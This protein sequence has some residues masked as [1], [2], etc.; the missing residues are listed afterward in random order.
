[1]TKSFLNAFNE[2]EFNAYEINR[3]IVSYYLLVNKI[4][5]EKNSLIKNLLIKPSDKQQFKKLEDLYLKFKESEDLKF[6]F[7]D[8]IELFELVISPKE[9]IVTGAVYTPI[10][11]REF[12]VSQ[13]I[14][15]NPTIK[16]ADIACGCGGFLLT[17][18]QKIKQFSTRS[19]YDIIS[20]NLW[21]ID[22]ADYSVERTKI[23][24][25]LLALQNGEDVDLKF[26]LV[27]G[28]SLKF[29]WREKDEVVKIN[30][31]FDLIVGNP[32]YV[33]SRNIDKENKEY[34]DKWSV[35]KSGHPDLYIPFFQIAIENLN[36]NGVLGYITVNTFFKS[37]NGRLLREYFSM[38]SFSFKIIDFKDE[39]VFKK[40]N[41]YTCICFI[42]KKHSLFIDYCISPSDIITKIKAED[43]IKNQYSSLDNFS[44]WNLAAQNSFKAVIS[45]IE[46]LNNKLFSD[47]SFSTGIA[48]LKNSVFIFNHSRHDETFFY[49][50]KDDQEFAIEKAICREVIN[51]NKVTT[52]KEITNLKRKIIFPYYWDQ[53]QNKYK[54]ISQNNFRNNYPRAYGYLLSKKK[55]LANRD[56]GEGKYEKWFAFGRNQG[57]NV[58]GYKLFLPHIAKNPRFVFSAD[59]KLLFCN[60][61]AILSESEREL[62]VLKKIL[63][64]DIFWFYIKKTSK[65]YSSGYLSLG[66]NY[67]KQFSLPDFTEKEKDLIIETDSAKEILRFLLGKYGLSNSDISL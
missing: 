43:F 49:F 14:S 22:I 6:D 32:P 44:G 28:N 12:I 50:I 4:G 2:C 46:S 36:D 57:L 51:S 53:D 34:L 10:G 19:Y 64:S 63:E 37:V 66:K 62:K 55:I 40:R 18:A 26:N 54:T 8:L 7:E 41:T 45:K 42:Q 3:L 60:G 1:M 33:C 15:S 31:G 24:L 48:T 58:K 29:N 38:K 9:K 13:T 25:S 11:I 47:F 27:V 59:E 20:E 61:E 65:P 56:R 30:N 52:E 67:I 5:V 39:Q 35:S 16:I 17:V 21:G 23:V